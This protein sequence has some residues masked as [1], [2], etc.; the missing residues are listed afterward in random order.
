[1][2]TPCW[3]YDVE[4]DQVSLFP[5]IESL[6]EAENLP[7]Q[8]RFGYYKGPI[9]P[10]AIRYS[11]QG[12]GMSDREIQEYIHKKKARLYYVAWR[13]CEIKIYPG[14]E[15]LFEEIKMYRYLHGLEKEPMW[16]TTNLDDTCHV[17]RNFCYP[18]KS[19][20]RV[21]WTESLEGL[22]ASMSAG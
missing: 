8:A 7:R 10:R 19:Y 4:R 17:I 20:G 1:M 9:L 16:I 22:L 14:K 18:H 11:L 2:S 5:N 21:I 3:Y 15:G 6:L 12:E 13:E